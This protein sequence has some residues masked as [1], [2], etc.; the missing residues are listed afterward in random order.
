MDMIRSTL[1]KPSYLLL[2]IVLTVAFLALYMLFDARQGGNQLTLFH[3]TLRPLQYF[4]NRFGPAF[5][6]GRIALDLLIA[7]FSALLI[8]VTL[9]NYRAQSGLFT[10]SACSTG[11]T[12]ILGFAT[13]A[14]PSCV[15]PVLGTFGIIFTS[16]ALP[17][18]GFEFK[19]LALLIA[20]GTLVWLMMRYRQHVVSDPGNVQQGLS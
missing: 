8:A 9:D 14:C 5:T 4:L 3:A 13:F 15:I 20:L 17:L 7:F 2:V 16:E 1:R 19:L 11:A 10:G 18:F 6:Y 12:V